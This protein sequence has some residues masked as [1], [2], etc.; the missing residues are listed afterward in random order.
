MPVNLTDPYRL[1]NRSLGVT[2]TGMPI[3][4][5]R[6]LSEYGLTQETSDVPTMSPVE[7][8]SALKELGQM[9]AH[10]IG[11]VGAL[12]D[13]PGAMVRNKILGKDWTEPLVAPL[14]TAG[15]ATGRDVL[16]KLGWLGDT[17]ATSGTWSLDR[18]GRGALG[19]AAEVALDPTTYL[20]LGLGAATKAGK[21]MQALGSP[22]LR[23]L[24][25]ISG[26]GI[27][28]AWLQ[29]TIGQLLDQ[30]PKAAKYTQLLEDYAAKA[31]TTLDALK[32]ERLGSTVG[33]HVPFTNMTLPIPTPLDALAPRMDALAERAGNS[34]LGRHLRAGLDASM[35]SATSQAVQKVAPKVFDDVLDLTAEARSQVEPLLTAFDQR[36]WMDPVQM[37][38]NPRVQSSYAVA[39]T[40]G[41]TT[42]ASPLEYARRVSD[43]LG[44]D[45]L[46]YIE[47]KGIPG[48]KQ[49]DLTKY[50]HLGP[51]EA[52]E[53]KSI[54]DQY[55][56]IAEASRLAEA[57][58][59]TNMR[60]LDPAI[61]R[62]AHRRVNWLPDKTS[63]TFAGE[64]PLKVRQAAYQAER[65]AGMEYLP[66]KMLNEIS[67]DP[68][69]SGI[70]SKVTKLSPADKAALSQQLAAKYG[71][72]YA[73]EINHMLG[74]TNAKNVQ[75]GAI[76][77]WASH[78][79]PRYAE[80]HIPRYNTNPIETLTKRVEASSQVQAAARG[81]FDIINEHAVLGES[82]PSNL[83][84]H[85]TV[86]AVIDQTPGL[87]KGAATDDAHLAWLAD[88]FAPDKMAKD[89][90]LAALHA[91]FTA[92]FG[93]DAR[94][95]TEAMWM[96]GD[97]GNDVNRMMQTF[98]APEAMKPFVE[99]F[100]HWMGLWKK[101]ITIPW[102][103]FHMRNLV[104]GAIR[105][106]VAGHG[107]E[108]VKD[109]ANAFDLTF[110]GKMRATD[111]AKR[112]FPTESLTHDQAVAKLRNEMFSV[113]LVS[114]R[115]GPH[116]LG[117]AVNIGGQLLDVPGVTRSYQPSLK[118]GSLSKRFMGE[119]AQ[120]GG[121]LSYLAESQNRIGA[122]LNMR[123]KGMSPQAAAAK[124]RALQVAYD[125]MF[126]TSF[127]RTFATR[128]A[129]FWK[130]NKGVVPWTIKDLIEHP[131][132]PVAQLAKRTS[133]M[134][135]DTPL[136][137]EN[138]QG[139]AAIQ[140]PS[141]EPGGMKFIS[142][143]GMMEEPGYALAAPLLQLPF[144]V[145]Q[146]F[147]APVKA[148]ATP[149]SAGSE[150]L[151]G[152]ISN[153]NPL[154]KA[155]GEIAFGRST[156]FGGGEPGGRDIRTLSPQLGQAVSRAGN[157]AGWLANKLGANVNVD[158]PVRPG[159]IMPESIGRPFEYLWSSMPTARLSRVVSQ[160]F[161][162]KASI[163]ERALNLGSGVQ[164]MDVSPA[165]M[166]A[167]RNELLTA[168]MQNV[169]AKTFSK[170]YFPED[171]LLRM[172]WQERKQAE[173]LNRLNR[174]W[175]YQ[176]RQEQKQER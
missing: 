51:S 69:I 132:G 116:D 86:R 60:A 124:V 101:W 63:R 25:E 49:L 148:G 165:R 27:R 139:T 6:K 82:L 21:A 158:I 32:N 76:T 40:A 110:F 141:D 15:R 157:A 106:A 90:G 160:A 28:Q 135:A 93:T 95:W 147:G 5:A 77:E 145:A 85:V 42:A 117:S 20:S 171:S 57:K 18:L 31:G 68:T 37:A 94:K 129:P 104:S 170:P 41:L 44:N 47:T 29:G 46:H 142:T 167:Y 83:V 114:H 58:Y 8:Q 155:I 74:A 7:E 26:T 62:Y 136:L 73:T 154:V 162:P 166:N 128:F 119:W 64:T 10:A 67:M 59:G 149:M 121:Q 2:S 16:K 78:L 19:L 65:N 123:A 88:Y 153:T 13:V 96:P 66:T 71:P 134:R 54:L 176:R 55:E 126:S 161:D 56:T 133:T 4:F 30:S 174:W 105:N 144:S 138:V 50:P 48:V 72:K 113:G 24:A 79:D 115:A 3:N 108:H 103:S 92:Q 172:P 99:G 140:L 143:L 81:V 98:A 35:L 75:W 11:T 111:V 137:P 39:K 43:E 14:S 52:A 23:E 159:V 125:P 17:P 61:M 9:G 100:D 97:V 156:Y 38:A 120:R 122:Y 109:Y 12:L 34:Y 146:G 107:P 169:G 127:E 1:L 150:F 33:L 168:A 163:G 89:P 36:G 53:M 70:R 87:G 164:I 118:E 131:G 173:L 80:L 22:A 102:P 175:S 152:V 91:K 112:Y 151:R 84:P 45:M 130:F